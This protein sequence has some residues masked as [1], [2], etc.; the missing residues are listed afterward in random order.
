MIRRSW[1]L[2]DMDAS[3]VQLK[4]NNKPV[5]VCC[6]DSITHGHIGYNWVDSLRKDDTSKVYINAGINAD[7]TWNLN[8]RV[9]DIIKHNPD[10]ITI[11]IG[12]NDAIGSQPVKLIQDYYMETKGLPQKP[13]IEWYKEQLEFFIKNIK[14]TY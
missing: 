6:G 14:E 2:P 5:V 11:L 9:D 1:Q 12:T 8:Q 4:D 10:Y 13:S 3:S 7:L